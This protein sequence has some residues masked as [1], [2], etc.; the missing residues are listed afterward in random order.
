MGTINADVIAKALEHHIAILGKTGS[1]KSN[2]AKWMAEHLM[3]RG[4]RVCAID[5][6]GTWWGLRLTQKAKASKFKPVI[7]G[8]AHAD[9]P[10]GP[11]HG[12]AIAELVATMAESTIIDLRQMTVGGRTKFFAA[13]AETLLQKNAGALHLML[14]EAHLFAPQG[15]VNDPQSGAM[16]HATNNLVSLGRGNGI[17]VAMISQRPAKL[18]KDSLTQVETM[19]AMRLIAPQDRAAINDWVGEWGDVSRGRDIIS[20]LPSLPVGTGWV[21][22]PEQDLLQR[23]AFPLVSTLDTG[24]QDPV[25][26]GMAVLKF[27]IEAVTARLQSIAEDVVQNDPRKLKA[28]VAELEARVRQTPDQTLIDEAYQRGR[29]EGYAECAK[30]LGQK[31]LAFASEF[32]MATGEKPAGEPVK[33]PIPAKPK[34]EMP[35]PTVAT[36][37]S[38]PQAKILSALKA[39]KALG[40]DTPTKPMVAALAGYS[41]SSGGFNNLLS[42]LRTATRIDYPEPGKVSLLVDWEETSV[43]QAIGIFLSAL[44]LPQQKVL[45][46]LADGK[47]KSKPELAELTGYSPTSGGF[48]NILSS[49]RTMTAVD[50]PA[51]GFVQIEGWA[52][53]LVRQ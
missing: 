16:L 4:E 3:G 6:T 47:S 11:E 51:K 43:S 40:H 28:R 46:A 36:G 13:F 37:V 25:T 19:I 21:W 29:E 33:A 22:A 5:P 44:S 17:R 32:A 7:F 45:R 10:I 24:R 41:N 38:V 9:I 20:S 52:M 30:A 34:V 39:W 1:G 18:H 15:R 50:Y 2:A 8:G 31:V 23:V 27:D 14:D 26:Q 42:Q 53:Q 12:A 35:A 49:L 48:N